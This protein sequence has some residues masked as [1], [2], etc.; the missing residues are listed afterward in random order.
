M[1]NPP[2]KQTRT[3]RGY[4]KGLENNFKLRMQQ[5]SGEITGLSQLL[6]LSVMPPLKSYF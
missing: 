6:Q 2:K 1:E 4:G 3:E 5:R